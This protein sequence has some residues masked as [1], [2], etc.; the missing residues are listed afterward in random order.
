MVELI[1]LRDLPGIQRISELCLNPR[2]FEYPQRSYTQS[3]VDEVSTKLFCITAWET[4]YDFVRYT[5]FAQLGNAFDNEEEGED[6]EEEDEDL[7]EDESDLDDPDRVIHE[8]QF[9]VTSMVWP[10]SEPFWHAIGW[11]ISDGRGGE[12]ICAHLFARQ[13]IALEAKIHPAASF[14]P[15]A[16]GAPLFDGWGEPIKQEDRLAATLEEQAKAFL[17]R[18]GRR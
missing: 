6:L 13:I 11:D 8:Q 16:N 17:E 2:N 4:G 5:R 18:K 3:E 9:H 14:F 10:T 1:R 12:L 15:L 7:D